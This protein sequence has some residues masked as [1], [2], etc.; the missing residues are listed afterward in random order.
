MLKV[1]DINNFTFKSFLILY[2]TTKC[3]Y[4]EL[5]LIQYYF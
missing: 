5:L 4:Y 2:F 1:K 3:K